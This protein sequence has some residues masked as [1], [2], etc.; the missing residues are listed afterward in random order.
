MFFRISDVIAN[1]IESFDPGM[2]EKL[3]P[4]VAHLEEL[5]RSFSSGL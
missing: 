4:H 2:W 5:F 3:H 1:W